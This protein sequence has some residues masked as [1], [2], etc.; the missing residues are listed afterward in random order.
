MC[1]CPT[2][3]C[4][5]A[6]A[7]D[8]NVK[9]FSC[10]NC[11]KEYCLDCK[12]L[13]HKELSCEEFKITNDPSK[14]DEVALNFLKTQ[15]ARQCPKCKMWV[16]KTQGCDHMKCRCGYHFCYCC[17]DKLGGGDDYYCKN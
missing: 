7:Y 5:Y 3:D 10:P 14:A 11:K 13:F 15:K 12:S 6:F 4:N 8:P 17:G 1:W 2:A 16:M 9:H